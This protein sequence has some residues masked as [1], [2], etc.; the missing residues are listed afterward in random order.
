MIFPI[1]SIFLLISLTSSTEIYIQGSMKC[2]LNSEFRAKI[3]LIEEDATYLSS[4]LI[5]SKFL[6]TKSS[7]VSHNFS[8]K[9]TFDGGDGVLDNEYEPVLIIHHNCMDN[10]DGFGNVYRRFKTVPIWTP[11]ANFTGLSFKLDNRLDE[12]LPQ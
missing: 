9:G 7:G 10:P 5:K 12:N 11:S 2:N 1:F 8:I 4:D 6:G 3:D